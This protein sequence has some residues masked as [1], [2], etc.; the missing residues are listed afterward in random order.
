MPTVSVCAD[1]I[2]YGTTQK[3]PRGR[4]RFT[5]PIHLGAFV[6]VCECLLYIY[7]SQ[8][9]VTFTVRNALATRPMTFILQKVL[10]TTTLPGHQICPEH[11]LTD[12]RIA[13]LLPLS[14]IDP[15]TPE[16]HTLTRICHTWA[17]RICKMA[18]S[19]HNVGT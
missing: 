14:L 2:L 10:Y 19:I 16:V 1:R 7:I 4:C 8:G 6:P 9:D 12:H 5:R 18:C 3:V 17:Q 11:D 15:P 13:T